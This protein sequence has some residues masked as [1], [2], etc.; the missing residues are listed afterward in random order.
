MFYGYFP[1]FVYQFPHNKFVT[2]FFV[3]AKKTEDLG[4][5]NFP[6]ELKKR[7]KMVFVPNWFNV[8]LKTG[9]IL[10]FFLP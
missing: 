7:F 6:E 2:S 1:K 3:Q 4:E 9:V 10:L 8:D 5:V